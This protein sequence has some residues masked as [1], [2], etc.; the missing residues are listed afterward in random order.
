MIRIQP[1]RRYRFSAVT[2]PPI[3]LAL[4]FYDVQGSR[5]HME[6]GEVATAPEKATHAALVWPA[7]VTIEVR[8]QSITEAPADLASLLT[9]GRAARRRASRLDRKSST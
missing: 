9:T 1:G 3:T 8:H 7:G 2:M 5:I 6:R 4:A